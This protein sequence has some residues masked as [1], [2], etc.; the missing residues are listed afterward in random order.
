MG[1]RIIELE[2]PAIRYVR[3]EGLDQYNMG[4]LG[5]IG[6]GLLVAAGYWMKKGDW[7]TSL[8][9]LGLL[10]ALILRHYYWKRNEKIEWIELDDEGLLYLR[11]STTYRVTLEETV[12][13]KRVDSGEGS[14]WGTEI[15]LVTPRGTLRLDY[16]IDYV[17]RLIKEIRKRWSVE[18]A[19]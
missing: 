4:C 10:A 14:S 6:A 13:F 8:F 2:V 16:S 17:D 9:F 19:E 12:R 18:D 15:D 7:V 5:I 1:C 3:D 11:G